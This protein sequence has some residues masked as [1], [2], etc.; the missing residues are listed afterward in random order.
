LKGAGRIGLN[1]VADRAA[2]WLNGQDSRLNIRGAASANRR[3]F[4]LAK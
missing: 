1:A 3:S 2:V 4:R